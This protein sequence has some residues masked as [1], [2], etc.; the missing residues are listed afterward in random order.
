MRRLVPTLM[1]F[2]LCL[3]LA[4]ETTGGITGKV[5]TKDGKPI[6][7]AIVTL[8][9]TDI[10]FTKELKANAK[11][12]FMQIGLQPVM[13]DVTIV[14]PG[15]VTIQDRIK[16]PLGELTIKDFT[17][18]TA[19]EEK[20][21]AA[22]AA[23]VDEGAA[24]DNEGSDS[25][26]QAKDLYNVQNFK[27]AEPLLAKALT[28]LKGSI[29]K[30]KDVADKQILEDKLKTVSRT[31][32]VT[33]YK[34]GQQDKVP[35][36]LDLAKPLL[37]K[38]FEADAKDMTVLVALADIAKEQGDKTS[39]AKYQATLD[40]VNG[41]RPENAYN[42]GVV[43]Y[44]ANRIKEAKEHILKAIQI[45]PNF[46]DSY[47]MMGLIEAN[48]GNLKSAKEAFKKCLELSPS[49]KHAGECKEF[50]KGL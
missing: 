29:E 9:R 34:V 26:N 20:G 1:T 13:Y 41:P 4:A 50:V 38:A 33:L 28:A 36:K 48:N 25:F 45:D 31:Y 14:A 27:D 32:G 15:F 10:T 19:A 44:N 6:P 43:A 35:A 16:V 11:G 17:M 8:K 47:Y 30:T 3:S 23:P 37:L 18:L 49:G 39:Q 24:L 46:A 5:F 12:Q 2:P 42:D 7:S 22:S 21:S 40:E